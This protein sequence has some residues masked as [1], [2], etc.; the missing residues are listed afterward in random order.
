MVRR[1]QQIEV[2][3]HPVAS[4]TRNPPEGPEARARAS[5]AFAK[6]PE[7]QAWTSEA[8]RHDS[9]AQARPSEAGLDDGK[10]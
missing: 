8:R 5:K 7:V 2:V 10:A 6:D 9:E 4:F 3:F 1:R